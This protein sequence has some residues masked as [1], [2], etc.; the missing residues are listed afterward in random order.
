MPARVEIWHAGRCVASHER[1]YGRQQEVLEL[2]HYLDVLEEKPGAL[3]G[4]KP[5][6]RWRQL[7][8][9]PDSYDRLWQGLMERYGRQ[10]G[11][12]ELIGLLQ[13]GRSYGQGR[14]RLAVEKA[15]A[16]GCSDSAAVRY[17]MTAGELGPAQRQTLAVG[18]LARFERPLPNL[19][20]Y[21]QLLV[22]EQV[23]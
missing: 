10:K 3:E 16:L 20:N 2:E 13:L 8:R 12:K 9:W 22:G 21:D 15:L 7:G 1:C 6:A 19:S 5:L 14:L 23:Q 18:E 11:T 17:L 4:S